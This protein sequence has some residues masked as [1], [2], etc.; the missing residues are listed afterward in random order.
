MKYLEIKKYVFRYSNRD[1][2]ALLI[3]TKIMT[4]IFE[5][6]CCLNIASISEPCRVRHTHHGAHG[7]PYVI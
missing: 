4:A 7:A 5:F 1:F 2:C 6:M 3:F